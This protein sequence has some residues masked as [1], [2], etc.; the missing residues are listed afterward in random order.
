MNSISWEIKVPIIKN[1]LILKQIC[2]ALGIPFGILSVFFFIIKAYYGLMMVGATI[3]LSFLL[4][5]LIFR[6]TYDV[7]YSLSK[8]GVRCRNQ[9]KQS[10]R[11][12][13]L[14]AVTFILGLLANNLT[15]AGAGK[16]S[17]ARIDINVKW[18][19]IRKIRYKDKS[20]TIMIYAGL[21]ANF[22]MFCTDENYTIV[23]EYIV[24]VR[25]DK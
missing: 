6:G 18:K 13:K 17:G 9:K 16:L 22:A 14:S 15:A 1:T 5:M 19:Q 11:V 10:D 23:K 25:C 24:S 20:K 2:F 12:K 8:S 4:V 3:V 7:S 21:G